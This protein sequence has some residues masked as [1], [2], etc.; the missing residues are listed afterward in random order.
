MCAFDKGGAQR[1]TSEGSGHVARSARAKRREGLDR[2]G[3][4]GAKVKEGTKAIIVQC[5]RAGDNETRAP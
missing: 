5:F 3:Y 1:N 2:D 4:K